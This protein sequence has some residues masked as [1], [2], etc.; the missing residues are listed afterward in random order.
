M[1]SK[2]AVNRVLISVAGIIVV[3]GAAYGFLRFTGI[4]APNACL[5]EELKTIPNLSGMRFDIEYTNCDTLVKDEAVS[6]YV[7]P[8]SKEQSWIAKLF[9]R[10]TLIFRYDPGRADSLPPSIQ[11]SAKER[12]LISIPEVSS[13]IYQ[14]RK[15]R[16][17]FID[18]RI[19]HNM[20]P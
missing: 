6:V 4:I 14:S 9:N 11:A 18:Y 13:V 19:E 15:W 5:S 10:K 7:T 1:E 3:L 2:R 12:I 20:N 16:K 8:A 17:V